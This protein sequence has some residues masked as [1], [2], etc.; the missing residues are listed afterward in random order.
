MKTH[1]YFEYKEGRKIHIPLVVFKYEILNS[2]FN[3]FTIKLKSQ[4]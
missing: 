1:I 4:L 3:I 2:T